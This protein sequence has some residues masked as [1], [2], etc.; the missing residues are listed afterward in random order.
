MLAKKKIRK[1]ERKVQEVQVRATTLL[2]LEDEG[3]RK[4]RGVFK[5]IKIWILF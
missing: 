2:V 5:K 1:C 4:G 3:R